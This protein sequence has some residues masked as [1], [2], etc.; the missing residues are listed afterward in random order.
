MNTFLPGNRS[1]NH[2]VIFIVLSSVTVIFVDVDDDDPEKWQVLFKVLTIIN[3]S[4][5]LSHNGSGS[6]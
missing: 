6:D 5:C 2:F 3:K 1:H 4:K